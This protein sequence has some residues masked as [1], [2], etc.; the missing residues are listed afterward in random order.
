MAQYRIEATSEKKNL[1]VS[2]IAPTF[3]ANPEEDETTER[4]TQ[5]PSPA[6]F[7]SKAEADAQAAKFADW[8]NHE[9]HQAAFDWVGKATAV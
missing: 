4:A 6:N 9:D 8:L 1:T 5:F 7:A 3:I 2:N